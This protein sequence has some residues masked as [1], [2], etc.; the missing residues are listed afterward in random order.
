MY[1][2]NITDR[3]IHTVRRILPHDNVIIRPSVLPSEW[4]QTQ[5][6]DSSDEDV[7]FWPEVPLL[8]PAPPRSG[9]RPELCGTCGAPLCEFYT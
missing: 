2:N 5:Q 8:L 7:I 1:T 6:M 9:R 4:P 3:H